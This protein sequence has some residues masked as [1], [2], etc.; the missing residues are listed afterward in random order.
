[1]IHCGNGKEPTLDRT[2]HFVGINYQYGK[3]TARVCARSVRYCL[4]FIS[5]RIISL[6]HHFCIAADY[7]IPL[8]LIQIIYIGS[9]IEQDNLKLPRNFQGI[10]SK[11]PPNFPE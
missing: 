4:H 5:P 7:S 1:M 2:Y 6:D 3:E 9:R 11:F 8:I 10:I